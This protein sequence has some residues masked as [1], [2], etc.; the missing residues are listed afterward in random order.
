MAAEAG[1]T[2]EAGAVQARGTAQSPI[3]VQSDKTRLGQAA[4]PGDWNRW[5]FGPGSINT[6]LDHVH[7]HHG[8]GVRVQG[9]APVFNYLVLNNHAGAAISV[10]LAAS[11]TGVGNQASGNGLNGIAVPPGQMT[12]QVRWGL[13]GL[14]YIVTAGEVSVGAK[15]SINLVSPNTV[16][17]DNTAT[18]AL[19][20]TRLSGMSGIRFDRP[21]LS[22]VILPGNSAGQANVAVTAVDGAAMGPAGL[23]ALVDAGEIHVP[24]ALTVVQARPVIGSVNP[25][26]VFMD[27]GA[28]LLTLDGRGFTNQSEVLVN[29]AALPTQFIATRRLS[30][31]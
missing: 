2:I 12:G 16:E 28:V 14:P 30:A 21:D 13:R 29:G 25:A 22:A 1:V 7:F 5:T 6:R 19:T 3:L 26:K 9:S 20:G 23:R 27:Q 4:A 24:D 10:D 8:Q 15:P 18:V 31:T 11:P 17:Q